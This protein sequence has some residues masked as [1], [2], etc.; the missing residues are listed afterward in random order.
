M[1]FHRATQRRGNQAKHYE[2]KHQADSCL[3]TSLT[4]ESH[5][6]EMTETTVCWHCSAPLAVRRFGRHQRNNHNKKNPILN[7][8]C[9]EYLN[10]SFIPNRFCRAFSVSFKSCLVQKRLS[11]LLIPSCYTTR[12]IDLFGNLPQRIGMENKQGYK[13][14]KI[15]RRVCGADQF[16]PTVC[17]GAA[18]ALAGQ[19]LDQPDSRQTQTMKRGRPSSRSVF[20]Q[21]RRTVE[22]KGRLADSQTDRVDVNNTDSTG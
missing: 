17:T 22:N 14:W 11:G 3:P 5:H 13:L 1:K 8:K 10:M 9:D 15:W 19:L 18:L 2:N 4:C 21:S 7:F 6:V 12:H 16:K 20:G